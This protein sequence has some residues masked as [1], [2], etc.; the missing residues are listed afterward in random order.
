[1]L[2]YLPVPEPGWPGGTEFSL[3]QGYP[4]GCF[5]RHIWVEDKALRMRNRSWGWGAAADLLLAYFRGRAD[6]GGQEQ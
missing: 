1:M 4:A 5:V 6:A 2:L 3:C